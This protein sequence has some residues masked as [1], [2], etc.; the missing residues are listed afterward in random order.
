MQSILPMRDGSA[1]RLTTAKYFTPSHR[2]IHNKGIEPDYT[3]KM[4]SEQMRDIMMK[5]SPGIMET[6]ESE[7]RN[8]VANAVDP[9]L[10]KALGI[11]T[12]LLKLD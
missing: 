12:S 10:D 8:R 2:T 1:L 6:L 3:V 4:T 5:R 9:Q 11:L 7:E